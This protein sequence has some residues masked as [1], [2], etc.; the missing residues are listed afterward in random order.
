MQMPLIGNKR[1]L[2]SINTMTLNGKIPHAI[3]IEGEKGLGKKTLAKYIAKARL[4]GEAEK[5]CLKCK[6]CR[7]VEVGSHP[8][9]ITVSPEGQS[10]KVD[11]IRTLRSE[12]YMSAT[13]CRGRVFLIEQ[14][15]LMNQ[16]AQNALL[17]ILEEPPEG[18]CFILLASSASLLL[19]T[20]RSRCV[21]FTL[22]PVAVNDES[23]EFLKSKTGISFEKAKEVLALAD[24]NIGK[25]EQL[26]NT[27]DELVSVTAEK[28]VKKAAESN[29]FEV[30]SSLNSFMKSREQTNEMIFYLKEKIVCEIKNKTSGIYS[31]FSLKRLNR[32]YDGL[33][34]IEKSLEYNPPLSLVCNCVTAC[35]CDKLQ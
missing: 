8:D 22:A 28:I 10:I 4:C 21:C 27:S 1:I 7:L 34:E 32:C 31:N 35:L 24:G 2:R 3:I 11:K 15:D 33:C 20:I 19:Q 25:A 14:A 13:T 6:S 12:A 16:N 9:F 26:I 23:I 30:L 17:K 18:A 29:M 5:P